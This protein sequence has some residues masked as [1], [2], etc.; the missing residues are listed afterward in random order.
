MLV[1]KPFV[2]SFATEFDEKLAI[3]LVV[4]ARTQTDGRDFLRRRSCLAA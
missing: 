2:N 3:G 4:G 1:P